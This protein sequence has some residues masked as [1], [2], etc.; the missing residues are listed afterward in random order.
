M[1]F[2]QRLAAPSAVGLLVPL[3]HAGT[4]LAQEDSPPVSILSDILVPI[5]VIIDKILDYWVNGVTGNSLTSPWGEG[6]VESLATLVQQLTT[7]FAQFSLLL[8][9]NNAG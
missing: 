6:L 8:P 7:F 2:W 5:L 4:A 9:A 3:L 1:K